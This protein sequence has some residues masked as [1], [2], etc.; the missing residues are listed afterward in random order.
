MNIDHASLR[1]AATLLLTGQVLYIGVT[2]FHTDG[3]ANDHPAVFAEYAASG[4]W[5]AVHVAQFAAAAL[6]LGGLTALALGVRVMAGVTPW[7]GRFGAGLALVALAMYATL[8]AV[9]GVGNKQVDAAWVGASPADKA[10]RFADAE[11][12]RWLEWGVRSYLDFALG[13]AL[14]LV[15][16]AIVRISRLGPIACLMGLSGLAYLVQGWI[17]GSE[18]FTQTHTV[19]IV[20]AWALSLS[21]MIWLVVVAWRM[22]ERSAGPWP[23]GGVDEPG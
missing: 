22:Q 7:S 8:Q 15:A 11:G 1:L 14:L 17:V 20:L 4:N 12:M 2:H 13:A 9:D 5:T 19:L 18:G 10:A 23:A 16:S 6:L 21:W 3:K